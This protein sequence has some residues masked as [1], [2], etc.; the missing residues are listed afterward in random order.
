MAS[1]A[2]HFRKSEELLEMVDRPGWGDKKVNPLVLR[3]VGHAL[4]ASVSD[5]LADEMA[6]EEDRRNA[7]L[8][9][10]YRG[11]QL[12]SS[13]DP[14]RVKKVG[15]VTDHHFIGPDT[16]SCSAGTGGG[17][18]CGRPLTEHTLIGTPMSD[19]AVPRRRE[20][21]TGE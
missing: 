19:T 10:T 6:R 2:E 7:G 20:M 9:R 5:K 13:T 14:P 16:K 3:A 8:G 17:E 21:E 11:F 1:R 18:S 4:L 15:K 12:D